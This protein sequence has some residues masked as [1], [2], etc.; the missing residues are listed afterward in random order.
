[1]RDFRRRWERLRPLLWWGALAGL[2]VVALWPSLWV[3][4]LGTLQHAAAWLSDTVDAPHNR[5]SF[6]MGQPVPDPGPAFYWV[7]AFFRLTTVTTVGLGLAAFA[8]GSR[9]K[10]RSPLSRRATALLL[11]AAFALLFVLFLSTGSKKQDRYI[12]PLMP[13]LDFLAAAGWV[14]AAEKIAAGRKGRLALAAVT[15]LQAAIAGGSYPY[16]LSHYNLL[17]GGGPAAARTVLVGWG[18]GLDRAAGYLNSLPNADA[19]TAT[20]W[21]H[22]TFEPYFRGR[23]IERV[24]DEKLSRSAKPWLMA[25]YAVLYTNQ[26]QRQMPTPGLLQFLRASP[27]EYVARMG[28]IDY[29]AVY[30]SVGMQHGFASEARLV[31]QAELLGYN[32]FDEAGRPVAAAYPDSVAYLSL[33][34]EWQGKA[35]AEPVGVSLVD[36]GGVTRGWGNPVETVAPLPFEAW[37]EGMVVRDDFALLIFADT[38]PGDYRLSAWIDRPATGETV[39]VFP[40]AGETIT[41][42]A[43]PNE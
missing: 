15:G 42:V 6:F 25:D 36:A 3:E 38:P 12:T 23:A 40:L 41:V 1:R 20:A 37:Q 18:E 21:Y 13:A 11:L 16:Y 28:G 34:W 31:G 19:L 33:Y 27:P 14:W 26:I 22:S 8:G 29:A 10:T 30:R 43:R 4:P 2:T 5:G 7:I 32:L 24:G 35:E 39:G 17:A 9:V